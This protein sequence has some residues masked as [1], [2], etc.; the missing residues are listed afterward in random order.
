M[1]HIRKRVLV[2]TSPTTVIIQ[3]TEI[4]GPKILILLFCINVSVFHCQTFFISCN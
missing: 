2:L 3:T 4:I 1:L